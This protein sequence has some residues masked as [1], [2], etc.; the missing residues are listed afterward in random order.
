MTKKEIEDDAMNTF[1][2]DISFDIQIDG[3]YI[4]FRVANEKEADRLA[5]LIPPLFHDLDTIIT[6]STFNE[7]EDLIDKVLASNNG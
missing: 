3:K 5:E 6:F 7:V 2:K 1:G 4:D